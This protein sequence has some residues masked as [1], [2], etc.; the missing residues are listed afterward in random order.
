M[1][2][3][4]TIPPAVAALI[5]CGQLRVTK[6]SPEAFAD[7]LERLEQQ[8][9]KCPALRATDGNKEHPAIFHYFYGGTDIYICEYDKDDLMFGFTILNGDLQNA[10][11]GYTS[12]AEITAISVLNIDY[13]FKEQSIEAARYKQ[14]PRFFKK[15]QSL[16]N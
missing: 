12:R 6:Q 15:P 8:L 10:E 16:E 5:P 7:A 11:W 1:Q 3:A 14:Y 2:T 13:Y 9:E 4:I